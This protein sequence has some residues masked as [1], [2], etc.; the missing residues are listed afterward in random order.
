MDIVY[1]KDI[2]FKIKVKRLGFQKF[3]YELIKRYKN[4]VSK[5]L[6]E[7]VYEERI[8]DKERDLY[9]QTVYKIKKGKIGQILHKDKEQLSKH[10]KVN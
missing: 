8:I 7:G 2:F 10:K 6:S 5:Y 9:D 4:S 1:S 3:V